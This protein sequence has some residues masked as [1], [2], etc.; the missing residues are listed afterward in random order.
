[1]LWPCLWH[2]HMVAHVMRCP[3]SHH[4]PAG[5]WLSSGNAAS[6]SQTSEPRCFCRVTAQLSKAAKIEELIFSPSMC[7]GEGSAR[8]CT[9]CGHP[10]QVTVAQCWHRDTPRQWVPAPGAAMDMAPPGQSL[11]WIKGAGC[12]CPGATHCCPVSRHTAAYL[13]LRYKVGRQSQWQPEAKPNPSH[14]A[15]PGAMVVPP[16]WGCAPQDWGVTG[17]LTPSCLFPARVLLMVPASMC[18][19]GELGAGLSG[20]RG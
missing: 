7:S 6:G 16:P 3:P 9:A 12:F 20:H 2:W 10:N 18:L 14:G 15:A 13:I 8:F 11:G 19:G 5:V 17:S 4:C 1:M